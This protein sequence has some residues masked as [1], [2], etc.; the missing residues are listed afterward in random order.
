MTIL[1]ETVT[2][3]RA[4]TTKNVHYLDNSDLRL[5]LLKGE[6]MRPSRQGGCLASFGRFAQVRSP[7][8]RKTLARL[9]SHSWLISGLRRGLLAKFFRLSTVPL[10]VAKRAGQERCWVKYLGLSRPRSPVHPAVWY[11]AFVRSGG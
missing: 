4:F 7:G 11:M 8:E 10:S 2:K 6:N 5:Q 9:R 1:N 3:I